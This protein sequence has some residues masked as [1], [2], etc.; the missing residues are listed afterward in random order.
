MKR[1]VQSLVILIAVLLT[2]SLASCG[3][4]DKKINEATASLNDEISRLEAEISVLDGEIAEL[5]G[6]IDALEGENAELGAGRV[7]LEAEKAAL[8]NEKAAL[9]AEKSALE[10]EK[11]TLEAEKVTLEGEKAALS[12]RL[13]EI[14]S[15]IRCASGT[16]FYD[17]ESEI[18]YSWST[19]Q[20]FCVAEFTCST[21]GE[22]AFLST[23]DVTREDDRITAYFGDNVPSTVYDLPVFTGVYFNSDSEGYDEATNTFTIT[24]DVP[25]ILTFTGKNLLNL[26]EAS[27]HVIFAYVDGGMFVVESFMNPQKNILSVTDTSVTLTIDASYSFAHSCFNGFVIYDLATD[28]MYENTNITV[29][30]Q[31][32]PLPVDSEGYTLVSDKNELVSALKTAEKIRLTADIESQHGFQIYMEVLIDLAGYDIIVADENRKAF[33]VFNKYL[34]LR[35]S[36]GGS[37]LTN[38]IV[39]LEAARVK[40]G[41]AITVGDQGIILHGDLDLSDYSGEELIIYPYS[42]DTELLIPDGYAMYNMHGELLPVFLDALMEGLAFVRPVDEAPTD[43]WVTVT[44]A[45]ELN[46]ALENGGKVILAADIESEEGFTVWSDVVIELAG[47]DITVTSETS[48]SFLVNANCVILDSVGGSEINRDITLNYGSIKVIGDFTPADNIMIVVISGFIDLSDYTGNEL[49]LYVSSEASGVILP[50]GYSV[51][52]EYDGSLLPDYAP[53]NGVHYVYV[54]PTE[55]GS[56][57]EEPTPDPE[58]PGES[59]GFPVFTL[60]AEVKANF[61]DYNIPLSEIIAFFPSEVEMKYENG[62]FTVPDFGAAEVEVYDFATHNVTK[63]TFVDGVWTGEVELDPDARYGVNFYGQAGD[64]RWDVQYIDGK[65]DG[66]VR[67]NTEAKDSS[68][69]IYPDENFCF[70]QIDTVDGLIVEMAYTNEALTEQK[71]IWHASDISH[72][73]EVFYDADSNFMYATI[74][75]F[76]PSKYYYFF[77]EGWSEA[78]Y[79]YIEGGAA[80]PGYESYTVEDF[81]ALCPPPLG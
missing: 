42:H 56:D 44:T 35:D 48:A 58:E 60:P 17:G 80:A 77:P 31:K 71:V 45:E 53:G 76:S 20:S 21:C 67:I 26:V 55:Q 13:E 41:D 75:T 33:E 1:I 66:F 32:E 81:M 4:I 49:Y 47:Y 51:Y 63:L 69:H 43:E 62:V 73:I 15:E 34:E 59:N 7:E 8:E 5:N 19:D 16:H 27:E 14:N 22:L 28:T 70:L 72:T 74:Y 64:K 24:E 6:Q 18:K 65:R 23:Y 50:D 46:V 68:L 25:F 12:D 37:S 79:E 78:S 38:G 10:K 54:R 52:S 2:V 29:N 36:V 61:A 9:E 11:A 57:T 3:T 39:I 40:I 30:V